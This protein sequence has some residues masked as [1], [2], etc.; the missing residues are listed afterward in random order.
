MDGIISKAQTA[1]VPG[2][3]IA[4]NVILLREII[5]SFKKPMRGEQQFV[6]KADLAK[7]F[8]RVSWQFLFSVLPRYGFPLKFCTWIQSCVA[9]TKYTI[10]FNGTGDGFFLPTRGLC[11]GCAMSPYLFIL[12]MDPLARMLEMGRNQGAIRSLK[13]A[14]S[15]QPLT[16]SML[17]DDLLLMGKSTTQEVQQIVAILD[18]FSKLSGLTINNEKSKVWVCS[19]TTQRNKADLM[20]LLQVK[21]A[22][23]EE[24]YL[25]CPIAVEGNKAFDYLVEKFE[26]RLN[27]WKSKCLSH[28]GRLI[29]IKSVLSSLPIYAMGTIILPTRVVKKLTAIARNFFWGGNHDKKSMAYVAW[30]K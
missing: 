1:F 29:L 11:Q 13:V 2:R 27:N 4:E 3:E 9:S 10:L 12:A 8:D 19:G 28:V 5:H 21:D 24:K 14:R 22:S 18:K 30:D 6:L 16:C 7:A 20:N 23:S 25:G 17:A 15:A 26:N